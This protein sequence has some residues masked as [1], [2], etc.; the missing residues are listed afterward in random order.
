[1]NF[2]MLTDLVQFYPTVL[3]SIITFK[4]D[5]CLAAFSGVNYLCDFP[6]MFPFAECLV[7]S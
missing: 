6:P 5:T 3:Q 2:K 4:Y 1:M 7:L